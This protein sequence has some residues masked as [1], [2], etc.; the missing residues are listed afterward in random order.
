MSKQ[1]VKQ[2]AEIQ[3]KQMELLMKKRP[4]KRYERDYEIQKFTNE[5]E[6]VLTG[7]RVDLANAKLLLAVDDFDQETF[8]KVFEIKAG[9]W[10]VE[11]GWVVGRNPYMYPAMIMSKDDYL[12]NIMFTVRAKLVP[13]STHDI[14]LNIHCDWDEE[15]CTR[16]NAYVASLS[17]FWHGLVGFEKS[18]KY[19][20]SAATHIFDFDPE[21]EYLFSVANLGGKVL[22]IVDGQIVLA[23]KDP[24][25]IDINKVGKLGVEA[26]SSWFKFKDMRVYEL[27]Y[28]IVREYYLNE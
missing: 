20:I 12:G 21:K 28:K 15:K 26:F 19:D 14:N 9:R 8:E 16:G 10:Y 5:G 3:D 2:K 18:P 11:D 27:S 1:A 23:I 6:L 22:I 4:L 17:G 7:N 13:P 25:P 24:N